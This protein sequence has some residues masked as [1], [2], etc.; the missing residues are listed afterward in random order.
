MSGEHVDELTGVPTF[1]ALPAALEARGDSVA[2]VFLDIDALRR[3]NYDHGHLVADEV[4]AG[5]G[6]WLA[7]RARALQGSVFRVAGDEFLLLL[8]Q[9]TREQATEIANAIVSSIPPLAVPITLSAV[10]FAA[11]RDLAT[12]LKAT[13]DEFAEELY[14]AELASSRDH[15][16][17]VVKA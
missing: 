1:K 3:V 9:R 14:R 12:H 10:V 7:E 15:S 2:A 6:A 13:L 5:L 4:L 16:N 8:P 17:V 11:D